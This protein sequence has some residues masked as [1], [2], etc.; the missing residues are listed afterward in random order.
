M[1]R[2][3]KY[4]MVMSGLMLVFYFSG[5]LQST[6]S[7]TLLNILL[8]PES[9]GNTSGLLYVQISAVLLG[10]ATV[11]GIIVGYFTKNIELAIMSPLTLWVIDLLFDFVRVFLIVYNANIV[12]AILLFSPIMVLWVFIGIDWWRKVV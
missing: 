2:F 4:I 9:F 3:Y 6:V 7:S 5:L 11:G 10:I 1:E 12:L 8:T